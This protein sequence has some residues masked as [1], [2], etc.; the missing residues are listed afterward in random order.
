MGESSRTTFLG[1]PII[2]NPTPSGLSQMDVVYPED[3]RV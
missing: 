2:H 3:S 1:Y